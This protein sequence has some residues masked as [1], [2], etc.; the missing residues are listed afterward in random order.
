V[1]RQ[2]GL[3]RL[4]IGL[5]PRGASLPGDGRRN[6]RQGG[7][8]LCAP[9]M[10]AYPVNGAV[11]IRHRP[12]WGSACSF[13]GRGVRL[14]DPVASRPRALALS[15]PPPR[16]RVGSGW[17]V[18]WAGVAAGLTAAARC[19]ASAGVRKGRQCASPGVQQIRR[20]LPAGGCSGLSRAARAWWPWWRGSRACAWRPG[21]W[22]AL[23]AWRPE[24][25]RR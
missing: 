19:E 16:V 6:I 12:R 9:R 20:A 5:R 22:P 11:Y 21:R 17:A 14:V 24:R 23:R 13:C 1:G 7:R 4:I 2:R 18:A 3:F 25:S 10:P 8:S 15:P